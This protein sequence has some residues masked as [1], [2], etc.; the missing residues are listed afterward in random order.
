MKTDLQ[1]AEPVN[2]NMLISLAT[3]YSLAGKYQ[4]ALACYTALINHAKPTAEYYSDRAAI[5]SELYK[6]D[7]ATHDMSH[8]IKLDP[9]NATH[10]WLRGGYRLSHE[11]HKHGQIMESSNQEAI[12]KILNDYALSLEKDPARSAAWLN[13]LEINVILRRWDDAIAIY[14]ACRVYI[15][16]REFLVIFEFLGC[17]ALLLAGDDVSDDD[18]QSLNNMDIEVSVCAYRFSEIDGLLRDLA[19]E[20][21]DRNIIEKALDTRERFINHFSGTLNNDY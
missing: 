10:Y 1:I 15:D 2:D 4:Q 11:V 12:N 6:F 9:D 3:T 5:Y 13:L 14:G 20:G 8:A 21:Y 19:R 7:M 16:T 17:L 18:Q